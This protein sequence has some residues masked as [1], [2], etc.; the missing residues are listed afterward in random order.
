MI[1]RISNKVWREPWAIT[2]GAHESIKATLCNYLSGGH[3][4]NLV[5]S[6]QPRADLPPQSLEVANASGLAV[7]PVMGVIGKHLSM[8]ETEC[9]ACDVDNISAQLDAAMSDD[10][11]ERILFLF[12]TPGG[13][14]TG[15]PELAEQIAEASARKDTIAYPDTMCCSAGYWLASQCNFI[16]TSQSAEIGSVGVY[17]A[18]VDETARLEA[19]GI[20]VNAFYSGKWKLAGAPFKP[21]TEEEAERFQADVN[22]WHDRFKSAV[23][24][25]RKI[26]PD[27]LEGQTFDGY[28]AI[29]ANLSDGM[30]DRLDDLIALTL[31]NK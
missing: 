31:S 23:H 25:R 16:W 3:P 4:G 13:T 6:G 26:H 12:D 19:E 22:K 7:I 21:L 24:N 28:E 9:G 11:V 20:E 30:V 5:A 8:L 1:P 14:I 18:L 2:P 27:N 29:K 15:V 10:S 17:V